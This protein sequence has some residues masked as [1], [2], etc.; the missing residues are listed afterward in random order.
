MTRAPLPGLEPSSFPVYKRLGTNH[1]ATQV[2]SRFF[3]SL[4]LFCDCAPQAAVYNISPSLLGSSLLSLDT[5][6]IDNGKVRLQKNLAIFSFIT[7]MLKY[8]VHGQV[9]SLTASIF[10]AKDI[11]ETSS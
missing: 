3:K 5:T 8:V 4:S 11:L 1:F 9:F 2:K 10:L 7:L 6:Y